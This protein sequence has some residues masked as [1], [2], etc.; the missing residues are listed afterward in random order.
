MT[1]FSFRAFRF[2]TRC[3]DGRGVLYRQA[4]E[5]VRP[6]GRA[7]AFRVPVGADA[8]IGPLQALCSFA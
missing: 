8:L 7:M 1:S 5:G 2:A 4:D 6:Y 3:L